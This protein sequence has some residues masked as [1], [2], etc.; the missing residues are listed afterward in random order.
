M[1][2]PLCVGVLVCVV[3]CAAQTPEQQAREETKQ[4]TIADILSQ[5]LA[6]E[7]YAEEER[8]L[9]TYVYEQVDIL[10]EQHVVFRGSGDKLWLNTLRNRCVGLR[11]NDVLQ[12]KMRDN[13]LCDLDSFEGMS[14]F[15]WGIRSGTCTLGTFSPVTQEQVDAIEAAVEESR[16]R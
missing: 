7:E 15:M 5:P 11:R 9:S 8:C 1:N 13:R 14:S 16:G 2:R 10:D 6:A 12:F 4:E 3:G